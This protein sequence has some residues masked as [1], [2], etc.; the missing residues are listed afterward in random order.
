MALDKFIRQTDAVRKRPA[1]QSTSA[2]QRGGL[3]IEYGAQA[4]LTY[5]YSVAP[6]PLTRQFARRINKALRR[7]LMPNRSFEQLTKW[8]LLAFALLV[9]WDLAGMDLAVA[10]WFGTSAGFPLRDHWL[11]SGVLHK[12]ARGVA[13]ILQL[14]LVLAIWWPIG[15][16]NQLSR[17]ERVQMVVTSI[18]ALVV[19]ST[20][21]IWSQTSCPWE[22]TEFGGHVTYVSHW[23]WGSTDGGDGRCFPAGHASAG[24]CFLSGYFA[25]RTKAP[26]TAALWFVL[27]MVAGSV[28]G[29]AQ[30]VRGAHYLSHTL[31]TA[32]ICWASIALAYAAIY[33]IRAISGLAVSGDKSP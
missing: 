27:A 7:L 6:Y 2:S 16:L 9:L 15:V 32:W 13:W 10:R 11:L 29:L 17:F 21:K 33:K 8:S 18:L 12:G 26:K 23:S 24:F 14:A 25:F 31:W 30:Q 1:Y 5:G 3:A 22:L 20:V 19:I 28:T 4:V